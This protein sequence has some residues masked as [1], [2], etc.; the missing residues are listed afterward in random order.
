MGAHQLAINDTS[1]VIQ[2]ASA[3]K[4]ATLAPFW[5]ALPRANRAS[6]IRRPFSAPCPNTD[7]ATGA[8]QAAVDGT[9]VLNIPH[10][11]RLAA[12]ETRDG[13]SVDTCVRLG[14]AAMRQEARAIEAL[15]ARLD[16]SF[17]A[18]VDQLVACRGSVVV[19]GMGKAGLIGQK[20]SATFASTGTRGFFLHPADALHGD[21][22]RV[23][24]DDVVLALS[25]SGET[26]EI[27]R[28]L[29]SLRAIGAAIVALTSRAISSLARAANV[30]IAL[31]SVDEA[32]SLGLA[33]TTSTS[34][35]L[36]VGDALAVV[37]SQAKGFTA[38]DFARFHPAGA[39]GRRLARVEDHMRPLAACRVARAALRVREV[40]SSLRRPGR[41]T[42][43]IM[44][45]DDA[46]QLCG[47]FTDSDLARLFE[48][49][50][51]GDLDLAIERVMTRRPKTVSAGAA[52]SQAI[53]TMTAAK[54]SELPVVDAAGAPVGL[55][56]VTDVLAFL[57]AEVAAEYVAMSA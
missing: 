49:R 43:A 22:G 28:L 35:M 21:L 32:C 17:A 11:P 36:A 27:V 41:R 26:E 10:R 5:H 14:R 52:M 38:D 8:A 39:L 45:V 50:R 2:T 13:V 15:A 48:E 6:R 54:I 7:L 46:G 31:G 57:P 37:A 16:A 1:V 18:A 51:D 25:Q 24:A 53:E 4:Q 19:T 40:F 20:L 12:L 44:L 34:V 3:C 47:L 9:I 55:L 56:D 42:G 23:H 33:P 30:T 29:P